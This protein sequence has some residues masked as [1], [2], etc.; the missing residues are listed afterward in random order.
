MVNVYID[1]AC[2]NNGKPNAKAGYGIFFGD[3]DPRNEYGRVIGKQTNNTG[4]L[5]AFIRLIDIVKPCVCCIQ[6]DVYCDSKY[7][8]DSITTYGDKLKSNNWKTEK[9]TIPPNI[10]L[11]KKAYELYQENKK[12]I[13]LHHIDAHTGKTDIHSLGNAEADKLACLA[14]GKKPNDDNIIILD[15]ISFHN[16]DDAKKYGALWNINKKYWYVKN[17]NK[18]I[19]KLNELKTKKEIKENKETVKKN[20]IKIPYA[21][22]GEAKA[23]N[24]KWDASVKSWYYIESDISSEQKE[25]LLKLIV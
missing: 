8:L 2:S 3:K 19:D 7:V 11:V 6:I 13:K 23:N 15:W 18:N 16:K 20:Y 1:G 17:D 21:K 4:E 5:T 22:K 9:N 14:I 25:K 10:E 12:H 24:A